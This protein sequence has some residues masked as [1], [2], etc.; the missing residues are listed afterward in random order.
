MLIE[1]SEYPICPWCSKA[2]PSTH[3][4]YDLRNNHQERVTCT[5]CKKEFLVEK[6]TV[7][8][9]TTDTGEET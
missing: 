8:L 5:E 9:F 6:V 3:E 7:E 1:D 4:A 2:M